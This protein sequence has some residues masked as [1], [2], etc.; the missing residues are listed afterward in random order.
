M[1]RSCRIHVD[2]LVSA[3]VVLGESTALER[4]NYILGDDF[5]TS[6]S[7][8]GEGV[9]QIMQLPAPTRVDESSVSAEVRAMLSADRRIVAKGLKSLGWR[10]LY[11]SWR[12]GLQQALDEEKSDAEKSDDE[13]L[14]E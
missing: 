10:P 3:I 1:G 4:D 14:D 6:A 9:A 5:P 7:E 11:P 8:H 12:E 13:K 2:D